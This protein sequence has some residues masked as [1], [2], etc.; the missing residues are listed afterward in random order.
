MQSS[1]NAHC[2][3]VCVLLLPLVRM[4]AISKSRSAKSYRYWRAHY[5]W[6][7]SGDDD[8]DGLVVAVTE[9]RERE[10]ETKA[11]SNPITRIVIETHAYQTQWAPSG[12][13]TSTTRI[14]LLYTS[15]QMQQFIYS[16]RTK[17]HRARHRDRLPGHSSKMMLAAQYCLWFVLLVSGATYK[18]RMPVW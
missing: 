3:D 9:K 4:F 11:E 18:H 13:C 8:D 1:F 12:R 14:H 10:W 5:C 15:C 16:E 7:P 17:I 2:N 6:E